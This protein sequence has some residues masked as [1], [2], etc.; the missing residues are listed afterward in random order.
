[1][2]E[3]ERAKDGTRN[4][5]ADKSDEPGKSAGLEGAINKARHTILEL[6]FRA[7]LTDL[8]AVSYFHGDVPFMKLTFKSGSDNTPHPILIRFL[9]DTAREHWKRGLA[10]ALSKSE[11]GTQ[12]NRRW[13]HPH[14]DSESEDETFEGEPAQRPKTGS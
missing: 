11:T 1:M 7:S 6:K 13:K 10:Y 8:T 12:W 4:A 9:D 3:R 2:K 5:E 14:G